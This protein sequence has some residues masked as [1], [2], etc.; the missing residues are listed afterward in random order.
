MRH[1]RIRLGW[2]LAALLAL[3]GIGLAFEEQSLLTPDG[4]LHTVRAGK[5]IDLGI[6]GLTPSPDSFVIDWTARAQD[7]TIQTTI[8]PGTVSYQTKR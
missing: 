8:I 5:A 4:S 2:I 3:P 6:S 1:G 7:G